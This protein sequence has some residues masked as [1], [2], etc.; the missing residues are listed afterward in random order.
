LTL[1]E[2]AKQKAKRHVRPALH[3]VMRPDEAT[4]AGFPAVTGPPMAVETVIALVMSGIG[5]WGVF[6][7]GPV[8]G[9]GPI[10]F[11]LGALPSVSMILRRH[12]FIAVTSRQVIWVRVSR[13]NGLPSGEVRTAPLDAVGFAVGMRVLGDQALRYSW[14]GSRRR[15]I[16]VSRF[17]RTDMGEAL[18]TLRFAG[19]AVAS[20]DAITLRPRPT[21]RALKGGTSREH[22]RF[23]S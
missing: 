3:S 17:W 9:I 14:P 16:H 20:S 6:G 13:F 12:M 23:G 10:P 2:R 1:A 22:A 15:R 18:S 11:L 21:A 5:F 8:P 4:I 19:A 7:A